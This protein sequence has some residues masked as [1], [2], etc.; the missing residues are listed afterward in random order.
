MKPST[1]CRS[2]RTVLITT[3]A[4]IAASATTTV[5]SIVASTA[6]TAAAADNA[7]VIGNPQQGASVFR[8]N[9]S[10]CHILKAAHATGVIGPNLDKLKLSEA[11]VIAQVT[12]GGGLMPRYRSVLTKK[13]IQNVGAYVYVSTHERR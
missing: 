8:A 1:A 10:S 4:L 11:V 5:A 9:C 6:P 7:K 3:A 12:H 13:Q 2:L